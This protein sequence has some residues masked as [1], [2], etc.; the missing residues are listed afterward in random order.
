MTP[1]ALG[2]ALGLVLASGTLLVASGVLRNRRPRLAARMTPYLR[3]VPY[4]DRHAVISQT[5]VLPTSVWWSVFG[6]SVRRLAAGLESVLGGAAS[7]RR[8]LARQGVSTTVEQ[9]RVEQVLWGGAGFVA[10]AAVLLIWSVRSPVPAVPGLILCVSAFIAGVLLR[11]SWLT[12]TM[13]AR[14]RRMA[15]E[16]PTV[17]DLMALAV[18]A[19]E[20]PAAA[21][22]R[23][24]DSG[25]GDLSEEFRRV[26]AEIRTGTPITRAFDELAARTGLASIARF[27]EGLAVAIDRGTP[28]VDVLHA[29]AADARESSRRAL[30][31]TGA[32][33]EVVMMVPVVFLIL[34]VTIVF[35]F[36]PGVIGLHLTTP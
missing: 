16:F 24:V 18:A 7:V 30:I 15:E 13:R 27:A 3:D 11:D 10:S 35:A 14:E 2:G 33:K 23:V 19:G 25:H 12:H 28:L 34:P 29:Q 21:L 5:S 26:L 32:R 8:R 17:A 22:E 20:G 6:P 31:E 1:A 9:F 36:F 4:L